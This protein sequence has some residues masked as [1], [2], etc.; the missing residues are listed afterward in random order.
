MHSA[1]SKDKTPVSFP[2]AQ[3]KRTAE[4]YTFRGSLVRYEA[5]SF[6]LADATLG[7]AASEVSIQLQD[8]SRQ[9]AG[10][11][12]VR[13]ERARLEDLP[14]ANLRGSTCKG[15]EPPFDPPSAAVGGN[16]NRARFHTFGDEP[17]TANDNALPVPR[18][19]G[20]QKRQRQ[21]KIGVNCDDAE[22]LS[23]DHKARESGMSLA[24]Y[25][26]TCALGSPGPRAKRTPPINAK[27]LAT[28]TAALNKAGSNLN[29]IARVLNASRVTIAAGEYLAVL[30][31]VRAALDQILELV[32]RKNRL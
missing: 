23:I 20:S 16:G 25:L 11:Q 17:M 10:Q 2:T 7:C 29:Q 19:S 8:D 27:E 15:G 12:V 13:V 1:N 9:E 6:R 30:K 18:R 32:G 26:R 4:R 5:E 31:D 3:V 21:R 22:F 24:S 14:S 28:A